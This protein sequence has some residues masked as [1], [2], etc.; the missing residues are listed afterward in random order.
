MNVQE[1]FDQLTSGEFSQLAIG[2]QSNGAIDENNWAAVLDHI[3]LGLASLYTRFF[4]KEGRLTLDLA[5]PET[6]YTLDAADLL[7]VEQVLTLDGVA[8]DLNDAMKPLAVMLASMKVLRVPA[9]IV[10]QAADLPE[11]FQ[12]LTQLE[13]VYRAKHPKLVMDNLFAPDSTEVEL[14][15]S[16]LE[17]LL[18]FVASRVHQ[19]VGMGVQAEFNSSNNYFQRYEMACQALLNAGVT[20]DRSLESSQFHERGFV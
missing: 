17:A 15:E 18:M 10:N 3:N 6:V 7:K 20:M 2:G 16:H 12:N 19:P 8:L 1:I 5:P 14:P 11:D 9:D 13:V 4:L